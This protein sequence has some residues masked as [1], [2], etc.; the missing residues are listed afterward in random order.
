MLYA[1]PLFFGG[2]QSYQQ[3]GRDIRLEDKE[4]NAKEPMLVKAEKIAEP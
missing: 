2:R 3:S 1:I 4:L